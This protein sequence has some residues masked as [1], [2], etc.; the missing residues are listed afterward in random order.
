MAV[1]SSLVALGSP[2]PDFS[3][4]DLAGHVVGLTDFEDHSVLVVVFACNHCPY[5]QHIEHALGSMT[6]E[7]DD[8]AFVAICSNDSLAYPD[9]DVAHLHQQADRAGWDFP[10]LVDDSQQV[11]RE[12]GAVCTP[13]FFVYGVDRTL[14]YRG[15]F[16]AST[17]GNGEPLDGSLLRNALARVISGQPI[18]EPH[19]PSLG[20]SIKW[21]PERNA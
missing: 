14:A 10:Y 7:F 13:D 18:P 2:A 19:R 16:D 5:V 3:L 4:P 6:S 1:E 15:A 9:D 21:K 20:C 8:V 11:A 12:F 17:P